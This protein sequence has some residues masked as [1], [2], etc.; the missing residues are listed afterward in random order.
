VGRGGEDSLGLLTKR[1]FQQK[2]RLIELQVECF[3]VK[4]FVLVKS[5]A[6]KDT[7]QAKCSDTFW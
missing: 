5:K 1:L 7:M 6:F 2:F 3:E 4:S